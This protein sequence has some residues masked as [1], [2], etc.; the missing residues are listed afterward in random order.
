MTCR[1][2][3]TSWNSWNT[4]CSRK[5]G[6]IIKTP[7]SYIYLISIMPAFQRPPFWQ[8]AIHVHGEPCKIIFWD[9]V[10]LFID[11]GAVP[12][13]CFP[14]FFDGRLSLDHNIINII[15]RWKRRWYMLRQHYLPWTL[16]PLF[17]SLTWQGAHQL[18]EG[19]WLGWRRRGRCARC[20]ASLWGL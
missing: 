13:D 3:W 10:L 14:N 16:F 7:K 19:P 5:M 12:L 11:D 18:V 2:S 20:P 17:F 1:H 8:C 9:G 15:Y 4:C 6:R